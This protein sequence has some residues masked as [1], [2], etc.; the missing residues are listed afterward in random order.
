MASKPGRTG[1]RFARV[2]VLALPAI[3][4]SACEAERADSMA[5]APDWLAAPAEPVQLEIA[6]DDGRSRSKIITPNGGTVSA[7]GA[8]GTRYSLRIPRG[9]LLSDELITLTPVTQVGGLPFTGSRFETV[10]LEP[11]G[12][13]LL[14]VATLTIRSSIDV[15]AAEQVAFGY[16]GTGHD[17]HLAPI[18]PDARGRVEIPVVHFSGY[19]YG[20][21]AP[22]D[23]GRIALQRSANHQARLAARLAEVLRVE[24]AR[25]LTLDPDEV[26]TDTDV[27]AAMDDAFIEYYDAVI[28][29]LMQIA[30]SDERM[31]RC[32]LQ[33]YLAW[34]R[35]LLLLGWGEIE[36]TAESPARVVELQRRRAEAEAAFN[37]IFESATRKLVDR[38]VE[39]CRNEQD[40]SA[41]NTIIS[42]RRQR[43]LLG[44]KDGN[45]LKEDLERI[46]RC[47]TFEV[48]FRSVIERKT[49]TGG[50]YHHVAA[51]VPFSWLKDDQT[52]PLEYVAYRASGNPARDLFGSGLD[53]QTMGAAMMRDAEAI[54][55]AAGT[56]P[57]VAQVFAVLWNLN[58]KE[59]PGTNCEGEDDMQTVEV[60][61]DFSVIIAPGIPIELM[62]LTPVRAGSEMQITQGIQDG[63]TRATGDASTGA[64]ISARVAGPTVSEETH[65]ATTWARRHRK[66][67]VRVEGVQ[68]REEAGSAYQLALKPVSKGVWRAD[69]ET[70]GPA[71]LGISTSERSYVIVRHTPK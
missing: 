62:R 6:L 50:T 57:S 55:S 11:S 7:T 13:Q 12:L 10:Q 54:R 16:F 36:V 3:L 68:L 69:F 46:S 66:E 31:A 51:K 60:A 1:S 52:A 53:A 49:P 14:D 59:R 26:D 47:L 43:A 23:P 27:R 56:R 45:A 35:Q 44:H 30:L 63:L 29:P 20:R 4:A 34:E 40:F 39:R 32:A 25:V 19:G 65:W 21:A 58:E 5:D 28:R 8:D 42:I 24:R 38:A 22:N 15:P 17:A 18:L 64:A 41:V 48:E 33:R 67:A 70:D 2:I 61:E 71:A 9:A 37:E